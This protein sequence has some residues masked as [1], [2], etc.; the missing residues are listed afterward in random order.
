MSVDL[1]ESYKDLKSLSSTVW[2]LTSINDHINKQMNTNTLFFSQRS[3]SKSSANV[4]NNGYFEKV[5][6]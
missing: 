4:S 1:L 5:E 6:I 3:V 2:P